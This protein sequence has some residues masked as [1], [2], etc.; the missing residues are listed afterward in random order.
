MSDRSIFNNVVYTPL[1]E[2]LRLL[3]ER[4]KDPVL[5][6]KIEALLNGGIPEVLKK[7]KCAVFFRQ[8][9][10]PNH[11]GRHFIS[12]AKEFGLRPVFF[13]YEDD[14]FTSNNEFKHSLGQLRTHGVVNKNDIYPLEKI[15]VVDFSKNDGK[16]LKEVLTLWEEPL[17]DFHRKLF[18]FHNYKTEELDFYDASIWL[19]NNGEKA[20]QYYTKFFLLFISSGIL[21]E[22][23]LLNG[24]ETDFTKNIVLPAIQN[25]LDLT[26]LK[27]LIVPIGPIDLETDQ[28]WISYHPKIKDLIPK[29]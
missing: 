25:V 3:E 10:T 18:T 1:S 4:R 5:M 21:F 12:I 20:S 7:D 13:E 23:F 9:A 22:S 17:R 19:H 16:K 14:K 28:H 15:T 24:E 11:E 26:G 27:P 8:I 2:A 6:A 29:L